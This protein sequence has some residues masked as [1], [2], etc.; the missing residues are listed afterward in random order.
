MDPAHAEVVDAPQRRGDERHQLV[1]PALA[2]EERQAAEVLLVHLG[3]ETQGDSDRL[4]ARGAYCTTTRV[5]PNRV[6][7]QT[8]RPS[9]PNAS[10]E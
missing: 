4:V 5:M 10:A 6:P 9:L 8:V 1:E 3:G 2:L 7:N